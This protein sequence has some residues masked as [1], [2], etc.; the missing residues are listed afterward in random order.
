M[1]TPAIAPAPTGHLLGRTL[2][3]L[4]SALSDQGW[5]RETDRAKSCPG[6]PVHTFTSPDG[7]LRA[8]LTLFGENAAPRHRLELSAAHPDGGAMW[9]PAWAL[10]A[11][12]PPAALISTLTRAAIT[13][14]TGIA[15]DRRLPK[16]GWSQLR[17]FEY[18]GRLVENRFTGYGNRTASFFP[19]DPA[20]GEP[21][22]WLIVRPGFDGAPAAVHATAS[23]PPHLITA[24]AVTP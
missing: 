12:D 5:Q 7:R 11:D 20:L 10:R 24:A 14:P 19:V 13:G 2:T 22:A 6:R 8:E 1:S 21:A 15:P 9:H 18:G 3:E 16:A 17:V 23:T 4:L